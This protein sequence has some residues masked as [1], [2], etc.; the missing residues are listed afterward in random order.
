M[1]RILRNIGIMAH[2]DAGKTTLTERILLD[3]GRIHKAGDVHTGNTETDS[4]ALEKKHGIT[5]SA[6]AISCDW[7][8]ASITIIDTPGHVDFQIEVERSLRVLDGAIAV[9][10]AVS[11]VE[12]Q[13]E[14]VWR[15][16]DRL[17]VPRLCFVNKMD[18]VGAHLERTVDM[19]TERLGA[20]PLVLQ[21]PIGGEGDFAGVVDLV[22]M[23][24]LLWDGAGASPTVCAIPEGLRSAAEMQRQRLLETLADQDEAI[25]AAYLGGE[26]I[27]AADIKAAIRQACMAGRL[28]PVLC[29][30]AYRNVGVHPLLDA[31]VDYAPAPSD[32]PPVAGINPRSG[33]VE[34]RLPRPDQPFAALVSKVQASRFGTLA[35][36]RVYAGRIAAG[37]SV[38]NATADRAERI[39]RLLRMQADAQTEIDDASAG[40][41]VA[42]VGLKSVAA[43]DTL[44]D[45]AQPIVLDGFV[46]PAPVIEAVIEPRLGRDQERLGQALA[47]MAR[48]DPSLRV[49]I[50]ADSGQ[51]LLRGMGE[52]HLQIAVERLKEDYNVD[53]A[54]GAPQ[55]AYRAAASRPSEVDHTLRKQSGGPGQMARVRLAFAPLEDG[56][57]GLVFVD[58]TVGGAVPREFI[59]SIEKALRQSLLDGGPGGY[60]VLGLKVS[61]LDGA[62][63]QKDSSGLAFEL[64][65]KEAFRIGFE[66][67]APILLEPLM[68]VVVTTPEDYLGSIIGDLQS[69]RGRILATEPIPRGQDVTAEVPLAELF[70]YV[71]ALRSLSQGRAVYTMAFLR[72]APAPQGVTDKARQSA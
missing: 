19:I 20:N 53:A 23:Q 50:D 67:A 35:F 17:G 66:R 62:F 51:T 1:T 24:A 26:A 39:G 44:S 32:R 2:V 3:T 22:S 71:S 55:V 15:Q 43:G 37:T 28:T 13:S 41:V 40:D 31:I 34:H 38:T 6:A 47:L 16:A 65:T 9:F 45:P 49:V 33:E 57:T 25:M 21:V 52:L 72:Y 8:G 69:R 59:P 18:Q 42:I 54:I 27:G 63:H 58:K 68:R 30:S 12:P 29:G 48:S 4:H 11:G 5:I 36:I 14:T 56:E 61:L 64:A 70:N 46:I 10:S 7:R 60:P